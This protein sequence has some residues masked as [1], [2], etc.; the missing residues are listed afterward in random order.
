MQL[1]EYALL[2]ATA[3][4]GAIAAL[5]IRKDQLD[6]AKWLT[7]FSGAYLLGL[8][9][10]HLIPDLFETGALKYTG[11]WILAGFTLQILLEPLSKGIEHGH[12]HQV[13]RVQ[14]LPIMI[15]LTV[16]AFLE[17][18]PMTG[19]EHLED[20]T[21]N[22]GPINQLLFGIVV[23]KAPAAFALATMLR[24]S[25]LPRKQIFLLIGIFAVA[26][27]TAAFLSGAVGLPVQQLYVLLAM[28]TGSF[29]HLS[30]SILFESGQGQSH[31]ISWSKFAAV[32][33]GFLFSVFTS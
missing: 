18:L 31:T 8:A 20:Q 7:A 30:T 26:T 22:H 33:L 11:A 32:A 17:G 12:I 10:T 6:L 16:H 24:S 27:P 1:W 21:H 25:E 4:A 2:L 14:V 3:L 15:G 19:F 5:L 28:V 9:I 23:H 29:L 13:N